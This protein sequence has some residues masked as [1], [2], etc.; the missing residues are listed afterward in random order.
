MTPVQRFVHTPEEVHANQ[1]E[2][3]IQKESQAK[4][5]QGGEQVWMQ[6]SFVD[7]L[8]PS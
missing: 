4:E 2:E 5:E 7:L 1:L 3:Q 8:G 6:A